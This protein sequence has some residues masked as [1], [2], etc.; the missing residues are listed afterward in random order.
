MGI[1]L[2]CGFDEVAV[3]ELYRFANFKEYFTHT[4]FLI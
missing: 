3:K 2:I 4:I 1:Q